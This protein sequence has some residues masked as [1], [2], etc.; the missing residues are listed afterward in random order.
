MARL[1]LPTLLVCSVLALA[2]CGDSDGPDI[3]FSALDAAIEGFLADNA[4]EGA[5]MVV[6]HRDHGIVHL[7]AFGG[8]EVDRVSLLASSSKMISAGVLARLADE[9]LVDLDAPISTYLSAWGE[10]KTD[11][12]IA[13]LVSNSAGLVGLIDDPL[14]GKYLC[15]YLNVGSMQLCA[16]LIYQANDA[17]D[18]VPPDTQFRYGGGQWQ[19]AGGIAEVVSG[20]TWAELVEETYTRP[21]GL[22]A[23]GY[24]NQYALAFEGDVDSALGYPTFF[25]GDVGTLPATDNPNVEGGGYATAEDYGKLLL[26]HL[27]GGRCGDRRVL[28]D[29]AIARMHED[30]IAAYGGETLDP[31]LPGYGFGWWM[32]RTQPGLLADPGAYGASPW[33]DLERGYGVMILLEAEATLGASVR[34]LAQPILEDIF[35]A[36]A[37]SE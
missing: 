19:L 12:S 18:R 23:L 2:S 13:Q 14:Y 24:T 37:V 32:S 33:I 25:T 15:Q 29:A 30:H 36:L 9:G 4:L 17:E 1:L 22:D 20:R 8:F 26:M 11:I 31:S 10:H 6:V 28:S 27:R 7:R 16:Q 34:T 35:D 21:C 5:T 3:D